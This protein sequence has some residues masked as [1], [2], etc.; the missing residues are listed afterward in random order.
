MSVGFNQ[1][2]F[3]SLSLFRSD[4]FRTSFDATGEGTTSFSNF[5]ILLNDYSVSGIGET[6]N[7]PIFIIDGILDA[8]GKGEAS[9]D[10]ILFFKLESNFSGD[11]IGESNF[12]IFIIGRLLFKGKIMSK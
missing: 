7:F 3:T 10:G 5:L 4:I 11:G 9:H 12:E 8:D 1:V 2:G 6:S